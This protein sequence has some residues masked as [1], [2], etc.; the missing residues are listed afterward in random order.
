MSP[1]LVWINDFGVVGWSDSWFDDYEDSHYLQ[2]G[3]KTLWMILE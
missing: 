3:C 2:D 1:D